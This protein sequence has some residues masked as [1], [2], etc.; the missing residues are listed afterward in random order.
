VGQQSEEDSDA[1]DSNTLAKDLA[2]E[3]AA[4]MKKVEFPVN[5]FCNMFWFNGFMFAVQHKR[6]SCW[7]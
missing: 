6:F 5:L 1:D 3:R 2:K 4:L 7:S